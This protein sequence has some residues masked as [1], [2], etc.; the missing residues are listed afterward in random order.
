MA[1]CGV[2][3]KSRVK[4]IQK[5]FRNLNWLSQPVE[6]AFKRRQLATL[7]IS[8][9]QYQEHKRS[10]KV[11]LPDLYRV[12]Q[13]ECKML[14]R[15]GYVVVWM[16]LPKSTDS[17][18]VLFAVI[19][20]TLLA[21][22]PSQLQLVVPETWLFYRNL[23]ANVL[24]Q[25]HSAQ[26]YW[27]FLSASGTLHVTAQQGLMQHASYFLEAL[28]LSETSV[29]RRSLELPDFFEKNELTLHWWQLA[30]LFCLPE[31]SAEPFQAQKYKNVAK[32][33]A[34]VALSYGLL[35]S[36]AL[37]LR[38]SWLE[39][40]VAELKKSASS[41]VEQQS[42]LDEQLLLISHYD[43]LLN[44]RTD[45]SL[46]LAELATQIKDVAVIENVTVT[47]NLLTIRGSSQSATDVLAKL[48]ESGIWQESRFTQPVQRGTDG[49][50]FTITAIYQPQN[51]IT[52]KADTVASEVKP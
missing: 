10:Y 16:V 12:V 37:V 9:S 52:Q 7:V 36:A 18:E 2:R 6:K 41:L 46:M 15:P 21:G 26:N 39:Q 3:G 1:C 23:S 20:R 22:V 4:I 8:R 11:S 31:R 33:L 13:N 28:G 35:L 38:Q 30:G 44:N 27:A 40:D 34:V 50:M 42:R 32:V 5:L 49:D 29:E 48:A 51:N 43:K 17:Y 45:Y 24:Y 19:S 47:D 25:V 14:S